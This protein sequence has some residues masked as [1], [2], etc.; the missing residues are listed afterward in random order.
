[1]FVLVS[2]DSQDLPFVV[3]PFPSREAAQAWSVDHPD[4]DGGA[5]W[6][7]SMAHLTVP[8]EIEATTER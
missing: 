5:A 2:S 6:D 1:M 7:W 8:A 3:G 4:D